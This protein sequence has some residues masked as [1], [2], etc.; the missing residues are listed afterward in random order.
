MTQIDPPPPVRPTKTNM[1]Y[2]SAVHHLH[3]PET[4]GAAVATPFL[5]SS[6]R[7]EISA[8]R[9]WKK[10]K[11]SKKKR[12]GREGWG[13]RRISLVWLGP[14]GSILGVLSDLPAS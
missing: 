3:S 11:E 9:K 6:K 14:L 2:P 10:R 13:G 5:D 1:K 7:G 8:E 12:G 4:K